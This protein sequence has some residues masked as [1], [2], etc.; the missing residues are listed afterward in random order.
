MK[1]IEAI[2]A[3][4]ICFLLNGCWNNDVGR[5]YYSSGKILS[6]A[7][8]RNSLLDGPSFR[9]FESGVIMSKADYKNGLLNG[10]SESFY[11]SGKIKAKAGYK[12]G[13]LNGWSEKWN[14]NGQL[15]DKVCFIDGK[16]VSVNIKYM[17]VNSA[18]VSQ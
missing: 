7:T 16:V 12:E 5:S 4:A 10:E 9:Y 2:I 6:E 11:E 15:T 3:L 13:V 17:R 8:I 1:K 14:T 18:C